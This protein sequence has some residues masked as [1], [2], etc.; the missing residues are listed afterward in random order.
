M[1]ITGS[2]RGTFSS[3]LLSVFMMLVCLSA[4][5]AREPLDPAGRLHIPIG[6]ANSLDTL[7][8]FVE[9]EGSFSPGVG[10]YGVYVW[11]YDHSRRRLVAATMQDVC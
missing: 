1:K 10:S 9:A 3:I 6:I 8:T 11:V 7:K 2:F 4:A 5:K